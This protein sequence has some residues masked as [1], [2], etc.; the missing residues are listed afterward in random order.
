MIAILRTIRRARTRTSPAQPGR[1]RRRPGQSLVELAVAL[2]FVLLLMLGTVDL[3]RMFFDYI[4]IRNAVR[5]GAAYASRNPTDTAGAQSR[6][7]GHGSFAAGATVS[8]PSFSGSCTTAGGTGS[9]TMTAT[10]TFTPLT[11]SFLSN[12]GLGSVNLGATATM[13]CLT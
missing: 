5:E 1:G 8:G 4:E 2:P 11:T 10:R 12:W 6:V 3:G 7:T 9:V 13:R